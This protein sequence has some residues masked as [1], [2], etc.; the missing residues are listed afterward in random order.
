M[1][2]LVDTHV[3]LWFILDSPQLSA[4]ARASL[5]SAENSRSIS[6]ASVWEVSI[7]HSLGKLQL[8][9]GMPGFL[10][11]IERANFDL[12][13]IIPEHILMLGSLAAHHRDP[14]DRML[15]AQAKYEGMHLLTV[16]PQFKLYDVPL[17]DL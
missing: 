2:I 15:I 16:D 4:K 8:L 6:T 12:L 1:N 5:I 11:D 10:R 3:F 13:G 14:F 9:D 17:V 7:K